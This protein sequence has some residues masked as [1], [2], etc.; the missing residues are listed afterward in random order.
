MYP[1]QWMLVLSM[2]LPFSGAADTDKQ[3]VRTLT[4]SWASGARAIDFELPPGDI[5]IEPATDGKLSATIDVLCKYRGRSCDKLADKLSLEAQPGSD[6][7]R[8][9]VAGLPSKL[10]GGMSFR[11][12]IRVPR[13]I[14]VAVDMDVGELDVNSLEGDL[15]V[16]LGVGELR[17]RMPE[18]VVRFVEM[19]VGVGDGELVTTGQDV[20]SRGWLG[21]RV[22]WTGKGKS[23]VRVSLGVGQARITL[24]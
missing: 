22:D 20:E 8:L 19:S 14:Q 18:R 9:S 15:D 10:T 12:R 4:G 16:N 24:E 3:T 1:A 2:T 11:G 13:G 21:K 17:V 7:F 23:N 6:R 5:T